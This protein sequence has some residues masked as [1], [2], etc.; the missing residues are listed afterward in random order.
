MNKTI[1]NGLLVAM[2]ISWSGLVFSGQAG[3]QESSDQALSQTT[4]ATETADEKQLPSGIGWRLVRSLE[5]GKSG[6]FVHMVLVDKD[7][8]MDKTV[9]SAAITKLCSKEPEFCRIRFWIQE[10]FIPEK[11]TPTAE[12]LKAQKADHLF[13]RAGS[14]HRTLWSCSVDHDRSQCVEW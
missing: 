4:S 14:I 3:E 1:W 6:K 10:Y 13:N 5:M 8:Q 7:R 2:A 12:Q 9:Y 11:L